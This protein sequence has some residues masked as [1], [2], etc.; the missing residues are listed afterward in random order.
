MSATTLSSIP[1][2]KA[3]GVGWNNRLMVFVDSTQKNEAGQPITTITLGGTVIVVDVRIE[4]ECI[5]YTH[6]FISFHRL[7]LTKKDPS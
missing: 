1:S 2:T 3:L 4:Q 6:I 5:S 7:I